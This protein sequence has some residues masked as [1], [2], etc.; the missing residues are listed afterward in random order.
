MQFGPFAV[1]RDARQRR[2]RRGERRSSRSRSSPASPRRRRRWRRSRRPPRGSAAG[3]SWRRRFVG[4]PER[5]DRPRVDAVGDPG[6]RVHG[7]DRHA[8]VLPVHLRRVVLRA[9]RAE[10]HRVGLGRVVG[11][12]GE[13]G[14]REREG[15][16][17]SSRAVRRCRSARRRSGLRT[18]PRRRSRRQSAPLAT[19]SGAER[20][21]ALRVRCRRRTA[22]RTPS[23]RRRAVPATSWG[24]NWLQ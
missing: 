11:D 10:E 18:R 21:L 2:Q 9:A 8:D 16:G 3:R 15:S 14:E 19:A 1:R 12:V 24:E 5:E 4:L 20:G 13:G 6:V 7:V 17:R 22:R 23:A